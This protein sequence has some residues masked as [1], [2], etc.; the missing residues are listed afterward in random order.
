VF[1]DL[2]T[3][4]ARIKLGNQS[5]AWDDGQDGNAFTP[6]ISVTPPDPGLSVATWGCHAHF[7]SHFCDEDLANA[8]ADGGKYLE[9][10]KRKAAYD[11][12][13]QIWA[14]DMPAFITCFRPFTHAA[15]KKVHGIYDD[16]G[17]LSCSP[18]SLPGRGF[19]PAAAS[20]PASGWWRPTCFSVLS[21]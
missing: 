3:W 2:T 21:G 9:I 6:N 12:Y 15:L 19:G 20:R 14:N 17:A 10:V 13:Q 1:T 7:G 5:A 11:K 4:F 16:D 8:A 18:C